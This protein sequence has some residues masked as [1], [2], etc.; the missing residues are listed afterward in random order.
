MAVHRFF[1]PRD[2]RG[3]HTA[4]KVVHCYPT[5][6]VFGVIC[7]TVRSTAVL[8]SDLMI[9]RKTNSFV[10]FKGLRITDLLSLIISYKVAV[11][12]QIT[13]RSTF[14]NRVYSINTTTTGK[15]VT[16]SI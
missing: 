8:R 6:F 7:H 4:N 5:I 14:V 1:H 10:S 11:F 2:T 16:W 13:N 3:S 9:F 15:V 12:G